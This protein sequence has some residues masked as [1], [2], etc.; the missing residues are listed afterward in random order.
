MF[1]LVFLL[2]IL[3]LINPRHVHAEEDVSF[4]CVIPCDACN[5]TGY[6]D[7]P[8]CQGS[9]KDSNGD[10]CSTCVGVGKESGKAVCWHCTNGWINLG[11][12]DWTPATST[13]LATCTKCTATK[14]DIAISADTKVMDTYALLGGKVY[15]NAIL[16]VG[17]PGY[18]HTFIVDELPSNPLPVL[19]SGEY[20]TPA[21]SNF[22]KDINSM[23]LNLYYLTTDEKI[24]AFINETSGVCL[25]DFPEVN[26]EE[27]IYYGGFVDSIDEID[28]TNSED[29]I[30][31]YWVKPKEDIT[32]QVQY[33]YQR[34]EVGGMVDMIVRN[35]VVKDDN[36]V[37]QSILDVDVPG[38]EH[39]RKWSDRYVYLTTTY[40]TGD[41]VI[42]NRND[43]DTSSETYINKIYVYV[44]YKMKGIKY[45]YDDNLVYTDN[46]VN[47]RNATLWNASS[48]D[49]T[50]WCQF[51]KLAYQ[52]RNTKQ[53]IESIQDLQLIYEQMN[54]ENDYFVEVEVIKIHDKYYYGSSIIYKRNNS[55]LTNA[56]INKILSENILSCEHTITYTFEDVD[57]IGNGTKL[58]TYQYKIK[59][60]DSEEKVKII[61]TDKINS[62][63][64]YGS[65]LYYPINQKLSTGQIV[66]DMKRVGVLPNTNLS[67]QFTG[68]NEASSNFLSGKN[69]Q[70]GTYSYV[71]DYESATGESGSTQVFLNTLE[72]KVFTT[73]DP[74][75]QPKDYMKI[76]ENGIVILVIVGGIALLLYLL[77]GRKSNK[78]R[79]KKWK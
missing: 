36:Y 14:G 41:T 79:K 66:E 1:S 20:W 42:L 25:T 34:E 18:A 38:V 74:V 51:E 28:T 69:N 62:D 60:E 11:N 58:G 35:D 12:H 48:I 53:R 63:Y 47:W 78:K 61:V 29:K 33:V 16:S 10:P 37:I 7:C 77:L 45:Y 73:D 4:A 21:V 2:T 39:D 3:S 24:Y 56:T 13:S 52:E 17:I 27:L 57:Y 59:F 32:Y 49:K 40:H 23:V 31:L 30:Y 22:E 71:V 55:F 54:P 67:T 50:N 65:N 64:I 6:V 8:D 26:L 9:A 19:M 46:N 72:A 75:E 44:E 68:R 5:H 70:V 43:Y 15:K 76:V